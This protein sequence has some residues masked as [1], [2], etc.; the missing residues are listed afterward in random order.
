[1]KGYEL[2]PVPCS[3]KFREGPQ[4]EWVGHGGQDVEGAPSPSAGHRTRTSSPDAF[5]EVS[6]PRPQ[7]LT[8][9]SK[10][11]KQREYVMCTSGP[12]DIDLWDGS[13]GM[14][15]LSS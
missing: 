9:A 10:R 5:A 12:C 13:I 15:A 11:L 7:Q 1:M 3:A 14:G 4:P 6:H 2:A 8:M